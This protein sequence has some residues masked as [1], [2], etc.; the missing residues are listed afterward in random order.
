MGS[1]QESLRPVELDALDSYF[2]LNRF[3]VGGLQKEISIQ[4]QSL[5]IACYPERMSLY[6]VGGH[7]EDLLALPQEHFLAISTVFTYLK[8]TIEKLCL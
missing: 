2:P 1:G 8:E 6:E 7:E 5:H 4:C 3:L